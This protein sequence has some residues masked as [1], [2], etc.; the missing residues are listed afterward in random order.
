MLYIREAER[1]D[2]RSLVEMLADDILGAARE[3]GTVSEDIPVDGCY[4]EAFERILASPDNCIL[5]VYEEITPGDVIAFCQV[6]LTPY[7]S[8]G[9]TMRA[10]IE[11]VRVASGY[12]GQGIGSFLIEEAVKY[13]GE[14]GAKMVQLTT[15]KRRADAKRFYERLGFEA[16]HEG[17][18]KWL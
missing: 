16:T 15:D 5:I 6:T 18:K 10:T 14:H 2:L 8:H 3:R 1:A 11:N 9:G 7:L 17:M 12:R 13:A 4:A